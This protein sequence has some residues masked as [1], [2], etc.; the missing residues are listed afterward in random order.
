MQVVTHWLLRIKAHS[1]TRG[2]L[3][4]QV[5]K[6]KKIMMTRT[7]KCKLGH[8]TLNDFEIQMNHSII[9][10]KKLLLTK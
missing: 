9:N 8:F 10:R 5:F 6:Y 3:R 2:V 4:L 1:L 7:K